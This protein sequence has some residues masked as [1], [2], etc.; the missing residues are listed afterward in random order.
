MLDVH[1]HIIPILV[2]RLKFEVVFSI[3]GL[4][5]K[6]RE[7]LHDLE[8]KIEPFDKFRREVNRRWGGLDGIE[9][10]YRGAGASVPELQRQAG[11]GLLKVR[12][13]DDRGVMKNCWGGLGALQ[14]GWKRQGDDGGT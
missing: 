12:E 3:P 7:A 11:G 13:L 6:S 9:K 8:T 14:R 5:R 2:G 1:L 10:S 4:K